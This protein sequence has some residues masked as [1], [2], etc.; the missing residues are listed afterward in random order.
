M[1]DKIEK[2]VQAYQKLRESSKCLVMST[3]D[4]SGRPDA[5]TVP[6]IFDEQGNLIVFISQLA[7]HTTN[8]LEQPQ[9][10]IM[11]VEDEAV[12][13]DLATKGVNGFVYNK[14]TLEKAKSVAVLSFVKG[15]SGKL[16]TDEYV[17]SK[18]NVWEVFDAGIAWIDCRRKNAQ[19]GSG[20]RPRFT[21]SS[22]SAFRRDAAIL[23][24]GVR[25]PGTLC[26]GY[27][28]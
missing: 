17:T 23:A 9:L 14:G 5:S 25:S 24:L 15:K 28:L 2:V 27:E 13:S 21:G 26:P 20:R 4:T 12:I 8:L 1:N 16:D 7:K 19:T 22:S 3:V 18:A 6:Y 10:A 11:L